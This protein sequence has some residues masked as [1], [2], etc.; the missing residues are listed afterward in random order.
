MRAH[1]SF[2][3]LHLDDPHERVRAL[4]SVLHYVENKADFRLWIGK[5]E[6]IKCALIYSQLGYGDRALARPDFRPS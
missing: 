1:S 2:F 4:F 6:A 5:F 3:L